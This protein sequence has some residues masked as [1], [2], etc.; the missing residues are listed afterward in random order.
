MST[1]PVPAVVVSEGFDGRCGDVWHWCL[2]GRN[3]WHLTRE[4]EL[5]PLS[6]AEPDECRRYVG[7][8]SRMAMGD[9]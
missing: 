8:F 5:Y 6:L 7:A 4:I 3:V 9:A 2:S 1:T